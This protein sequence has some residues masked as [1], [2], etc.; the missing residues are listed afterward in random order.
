MDKGQYS[1]ANDT[2]C[3]QGCEEG[4]TWVVSIDSGVYGGQESKGPVVTDSS[5]NSGQRMD[6]G[7]TAGWNL[8]TALPTDLEKPSRVCSGLLWYNT[9]VTLILNLGDVAQII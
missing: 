2:N 1:E 5:G 3:E 4:G 6:S 7:W 9:V 8:H